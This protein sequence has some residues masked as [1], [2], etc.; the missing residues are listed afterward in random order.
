MTVKI[1]AIR[2][3]KENNIETF[4][5]SANAAMLDA[6]TTLGFADSAIINVD[7]IHVGDYVYPIVIYTE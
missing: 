3:H 4:N 1:H 7:V 5:L 2:I 6:Q